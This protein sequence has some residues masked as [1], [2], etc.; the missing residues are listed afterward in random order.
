[1]ASVSGSGSVSL[2]LNHSA[3]IG[4]GVEHRAVFLEPWSSSPQF[5][6]IMVEAET[7]TSSDN[8][9]ARHSRIR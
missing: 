6:A 3:F 5:G 1:M 2:V 9:I 7:R 8:R 4:S